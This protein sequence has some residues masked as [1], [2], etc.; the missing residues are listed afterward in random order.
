VTAGDI[1]VDQRVRV[2]NPEQHIASLNE[3]GQLE[4]RLKL[5]RSWGYV[6]AEEN[7]SDT[8]PVGYIP[9]DSIHGPVQKVA[10]KVLGTR[11][12]QSTDYER[13]TLEVTTDG[14][15][16]PQNAISE[17]SAHLRSMLSLFENIEETA[18]PQKKRGREKDEEQ[19]SASLAAQWGEKSLGEIGLS[20]R[21]IKILE[22][23]EI[24]TVGELLVKDSKDVKKIPGFGRKALR[25]LSEALERNGLV[26]GVPV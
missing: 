20:S 3:K 9:I 23:N 12:G 11:V 19:A 8:L 5:R 15:L 24:K 13:L 16:A 1:R 14:T 26:L 18:R 6:P 4:I 7:R 25:D 17:A 22:N 2:V 21:V 10:F